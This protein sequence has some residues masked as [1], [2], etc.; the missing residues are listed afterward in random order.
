M[1]KIKKKLSE[2]ERTASDV[3]SLSGVRKKRLSP[4][5]DPVWRLILLISA[6][7]ASAWLIRI[8]F[9]FTHPLVVWIV[10]LL[11]GASWVAAIRM[12]L[13][14]AKLKKF[15]IIWLASGFLLLLIFNA[16]SG[17]WIAAV[18]FSS[19]FLLFRRYRPYRHLTS[20]RRA[21]IFLLGLVVFSLITVGFLPGKMEVA[22]QPR[23][24]DYPQAKDF[25]PSA[26]KLD[27]LV[28]FG[29]DL[30]SY[31]LGSL[32]LF[33][34]FSLLHIFFTIRLHFMKLRPKLAVSAFLLV[35]VPLFLVI[36][37]GLVTLYSIL[38]E[39]RAARASTIL[40]DWANLAV[41]DKGFIH[42]ISDQSFSYEEKGEKILKA[43]DTP[44]WL[45][46]FLFA[47]NKEGSPYK[48]RAASESAEY[49]WIGSEL[50]LVNLGSIGKPDI[51]IQ[52][53]MMD[54]IMMNRLAKILRTDVRLSFSN[55][56]TFTVAGDKVIQSVE[57]DSQSLKDI[58]GKFLPEDTDQQAKEKP[59]ASFW[60][61]PLYFGM[62][63]L[64][65]VSFES[66]KFVN[67]QILLLT[68]VSLSGIAS[69]LFSEKNPLSVAVMVAL[70]SLA[71][72][73]FILE[74]FAF[75][76]GIRISTGITSA[77]RALHRGTRRIAKGD[78]DTQ[79]NIPN[80]DELGDLAVSLNEMAAAVKQGRK[81]ALARERLE[82]EL[83]TARKIQKRLLPHEIPIFPG[84]EI[85]GTSLPSQQV[86]GDY[87]DFLDM[88][89]GQMGIAIADVSGK[90]IPAALLMANL[91]AS[92]HAQAVKPG[93]VAEVAFRMNNMLVRSTDSHM[94]ATFF[95]GI[96]DRNKSIFT[97]TNAGHNPPILFR[98]N[99]KIERLE[100]G[101]LLLGFLPDQQYMQQSVTL[102]PG[103][104]VV[105]YTDGV[106]EAVCPS[107]EM[108]ADGLFGEKRLIEIVRNSTAM[109][110]REIQSA[111][112]KA[113]SSHTANAPQYDDITLVI[114][115]RK[116]QGNFIK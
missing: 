44:T 1:A 98:T 20:R 87:F 49:F 52:G 29:R 21:G 106:T 39:S 46:E 83:E 76:F 59:A 13:L 42:T 102:E 80:E 107:F 81:E 31:A 33:W 64:D 6:G 67:K 108:S 47:L 104:V 11:A 103:D 14:D 5:N 90:G 114:I 105:L 10:A 71:G 19:V 40:Q 45:P 73:L 62:T 97:S 66:G 113:I 101:G 12:L 16:V 115:K 60:R 24:E 32:R 79:I 3:F 109:S 53:C 92:L 91:Q 55:P 50:W 9:G 112:L 96:L 54:S 15:W 30:A 93:K 63:H 8:L 17:M 88:G 85:A 65:V 27:S 36:V 41:K 23:S 56:I 72:I 37:I 69:E 26:V 86:G 68:E 95:Y 43:G 48:E 74:A 51:R 25:V 58:Y 89:T 100:A 22:T 2:P 4:L 28:S 116:E 78:L 34:F 75:Y 84:F 7:C 94:F 18:S 35:V 77:V 57:R 61:R 70:L 110:A 82:S 99:G 111:I 38:G